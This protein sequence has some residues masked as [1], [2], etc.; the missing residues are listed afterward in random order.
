MLPIVNYHSLEL[1]DVVAAR[2]RRLADNTWGFLGK[3][4]RRL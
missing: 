2:V 1:R 4:S 3:F